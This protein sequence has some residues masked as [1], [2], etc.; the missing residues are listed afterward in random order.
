MSNEEGGREGGREG[1]RKRQ[2]GLWLSWRIGSVMMTGLLSHT[3]F[4]HSLPVTSLCSSA[5][6]A[7][8]TITFHRYN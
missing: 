1:E 2:E 3:I 7:V 8:T 4:S 5:P 6:V